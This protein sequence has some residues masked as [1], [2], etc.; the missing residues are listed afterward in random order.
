MAFK[1]SK[2]KAASALIFLFCFAIYAATAPRGLY[3]GDWPEFV[4]AV[5]LM[6]I[7]HP[8]GY[9]LYVLLGKIFSY[10]PFSTLS[11]RIVLL[12]IVSSCAALVLFNVILFKLI[13]RQ[14]PALSKP[15]SLLISSLSTLILAFSGV[16]WSQS[17]NIKPYALNFFMIMLAVWLVLRY[18]ENRDSKF[19]LWLSFVSGLAV[20][21]HTM[22]VLIVP[23]IA[24]AVFLAQPPDRK[25]LLRSLW[26]FG[27]GLLVYLYLPI[28]SGMHPALDWGH[29]SRSAA[30][31]VKHILR[32]Q[33]NDFGAMVPISVKLKFIAD[34]G[35]QIFIQLGLF[36][37]L[38][39]AG[40][41]GFENDSLLFFLTLG[42]FF[43]S[44][45]GIIV[46]RTL[47]FSE[48]NINFYWL[49]Y[50]PAYAVAA[51]W[52]GLGAAKIAVYGQRL[53]LWSGQAAVF[54]LLVFAVLTFSSNWNRS[55]FSRFTFLD[56][57][58]AALLNSLEK[59]SVLVLEVEGASHDSIIFSIF[60]QQKVNN[61]R[62]DVYVIGPTI[63]AEPD[64]ENLE[65]IY[66]NSDTAAVRLGLLRYAHDKYGKDGRPIYTT[67][68]MQSNANDF[69]LV[70]NGLAFRLLKTAS[71]TPRI[72]N[73]SFGL[74]EVNRKLSEQ[75]LWGRDA[76]WKL[77]FSQAMASFASGDLEQAQK[78]I[79]K[80]QALNDSTNPYDQDIFKSWLKSN[81]LTR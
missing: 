54:I 1:D 77:Y 9:P 61:I 79:K 33:Y 66:K 57:Y 76:L 68:M 20:T 40:L 34:F 72:Q 44:S 75:N 47:G 13:S 81:N 48:Y 14:V 39:I 74:S 11:F 17:I 21:N 32:A 50:M 6:G 15:K 22:F 78:H 12:S 53:F 8:S 16:Y 3:F 67:F 30:D 49:Y 4:A 41:I 27:A 65:K 62:P 7:P 29:T 19:A 63:F 69:V 80:A 37:F 28:R 10:L 31:F 26:L 35:K 24:I 56:D 23:V 43:M 73:Y 55:N 25:T 5:K 70:S 38:G 64:Q 2:I 59:S 58:S 36:L 18:G 42:I 52:S 71:E 60:Y 45:I 51:M 46:L